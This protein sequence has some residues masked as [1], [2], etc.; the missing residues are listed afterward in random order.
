MIYFFVDIEIIQN[1]SMQI[2]EFHNLKL[3]KEH[4]ILMRDRLTQNINLIINL[5]NSF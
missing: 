5:Q 1:F 4:L 2:N 3:I